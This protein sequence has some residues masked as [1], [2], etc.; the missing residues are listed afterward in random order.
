MLGFDGLASAL[1]S[2]I[3]GVGD[4]FLT[5][6]VAF[7]GALGFWRTAFVGL[8]SVA[9]V[10]VFDLEAGDLNLFSEFAGTPILE[11]SI[12]LGRFDACRRFCAS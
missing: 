6:D 4:S 10:G 1:L 8:D 9:E 5:T 11:K 3:F 7:D 2:A 12:F